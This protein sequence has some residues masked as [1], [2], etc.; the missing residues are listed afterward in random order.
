MSFRK[1]FPLTFLIVVVLISYFT[2]KSPAS[3][4]GVYH[5][6]SEDGKWETNFKVFSQEN[7]I[8]LKG[9]LV[10][11]DKDI[12]KRFSE[13]DL[14]RNQINLFKRN[15]LS[16]GGSSIREGDDKFIIINYVQNDGSTYNKMT[17]KIRN[18][19]AELK[20]NKTE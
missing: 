7:G 14:K 6:V 20:V 2:L 13:D 9:E 3:T 4:L 12:I 10:C 11:K 17:I 8:L 5:G 18:Y 1:L 19:I 16:F 15:G